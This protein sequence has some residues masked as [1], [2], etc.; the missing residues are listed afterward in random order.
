[1]CWVV[2]IGVILLTGSGADKLSEL[3]SSRPP[4]EIMV[5]HLL[6]EVVE[7]GVDLE[8]LVTAVHSMMES[9][10]NRGS[11]CPGDCYL[12]CRLLRFR[13]VPDLAARDRENGLSHDRGTM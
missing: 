6:K 9:E 13:A 4:L 11:Q 10:W 7:G 8:H 1:M 2:S 5:Q 12:S 3:P